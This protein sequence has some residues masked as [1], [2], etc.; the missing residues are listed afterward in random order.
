LKQHKHLNN[1]CWKADAYVKKK[2]L[3][4]SP[5]LCFAKGKTSEWF[6]F[7]QGLL[8]I[9]NPDPNSPKFEELEPHFNVAVHYL[10]I[11]TI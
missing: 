11:L 5:N 7:Q 10:L 8:Q 2:K 1:R 3:P 4:P 9:Q 6:Y